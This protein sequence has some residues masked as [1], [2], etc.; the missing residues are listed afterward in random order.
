MEKFL[1]RLENKRNNYDGNFYVEFVPDN[2]FEFTV[3]KC[4]LIEFEQINDY[5]YLGS[6][7]AELFDALSDAFGID[8]TNKYEM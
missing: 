1:I 4:D 8:F 2:E 3:K 7:K 5:N 6:V